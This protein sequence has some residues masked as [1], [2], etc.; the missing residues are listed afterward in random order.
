LGKIRK[1]LLQAQGVLHLRVREFDGKS[2]LRRSFCDHPFPIH[3]A[4]TRNVRSVFL[5]GHF[6]SKEDCGFILV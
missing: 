2:M 6:Q 4:G 5:D 1:P 3:A